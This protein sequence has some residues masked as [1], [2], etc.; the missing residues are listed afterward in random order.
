MLITKSVGRFSSDAF[1]SEV[2]SLDGP[3]VRNLIGFNLDLLSQNVVPY[4]LLILAIVGALSEHLFKNAHSHS[5][6]V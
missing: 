2:S 1:V 3:V 4:L 5:E 6:E